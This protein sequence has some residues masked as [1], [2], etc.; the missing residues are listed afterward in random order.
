MNL[1]KLTIL[2]GCMGMLFSNALSYSETPLVL[3]QRSRGVTFQELEKYSFTPYFKG[4]NWILGTLSSNEIDLMRQQGF[5]LDI[6]DNDPWSEPYFLLSTSEGRDPSLVPP[7]LRGLARVKEGIIVKGY[8]EDLFKL[9]DHGLEFVKIH[10]RAIP[11]R[12][13]PFLREPQRSIPAL[14]N[15]EIQ[16]VSDSTITENL[17]KLVNF[18]TRYSCTDSIIAASQWIYEKFIEYGY[19]DVYLDSFSF[20]PFTPLPCSTQWNVVAI[21]QG[22]LAQEEVAIIGAHYDAISMDPNCD[23]DTLAPGADDNASGTAATL[24]VARVLSDIETDITLIFISFGAEE[25]GDFGSEHFAQNAYFSGMNLRVMINMDMIGFSDDYWDVRIWTDSSSIPY[26]SI[27]EEMANSYT[28]LIPL[29]EIG[30][31]PSD[32]FPFYEY[33][34]NTVTAN[35]PDPYPYYHTCNDDLENLNISYLAEVTEM[36]SASVIH[37]SNIPSSPANFTVLNVGDGT[38][39]FLSWDPNIENDVIGYNIYYGTNP[40]EYDSLKTVTSASD[41]LRN[42]SE[43]TTFYLAV[44]A[45]DTDGYESFLTN[46]IVIETT[47]RPLTPTDI[48]ATSL[49]SMISITWKR[50]IGELD[51]AGYN[52]YRLLLEGSSDTVQVGFVPDPT[53]NFQDNTAVP[54]V[55]YGYYVTAVDTQVPPIES[56]PTEEVTGRLATHDRGI[57]IVDNTT[58]GSGGPFAPTD[59]TVDSYYAE[60]FGTYNIGETWDVNDSLQTERA[61]MDYDLG[62]Y[63]GV[64]W[65]SDV[66]SGI[67]MAP[68][69]STMRKYLNG[70]GNFWLSGWKLIASLT[71]MYHDY[72]IFEDNSFISMYMGLDSAITVPNAEKDFIEARSLMGGYPDIKVDSLKVYPLGVLYDMEILLLPFHGTDPLYSYVSKDSVNSQFH[73]LPISLTNRSGYYN[74]VVTDFPLFFMDTETSKLLVQ[75][76]MEM[77]E[78]P[79][80]IT[81][82][83]LERIPLVYSLY[84]NYPNPFN[85]TTTISFDVPEERQHV[86]LTVY[87]LRG[88]HVKTLID[89]ELEP[90]SHKVVWDG[91]NELGNTVS[92]GVYI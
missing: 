10:K 88:R 11:L 1:N 13:G 75:A 39:L 7:G 48:D 3:L 72:Y 56:F 15:L 30:I 40:G 25:P 46:E 9:L 86:K 65:H 26:A 67:P 21:K 36:I 41:T 77:F 31:P 81:E 42:L 27:L 53:T 51:L 89:S 84:Q 45:F 24:E 59:D 76:V 62:I 44:S 83:E 52:V 87:D 16:Q 82:D 64:F 38:S 58:D 91:R 35:H 4:V 66:R 20:E 69:T 54:H 60:L 14:R 2:L 68:D 33:G 28:D 73:G 43:G 32:N 12:K 78:E 47:T 70:G 74:F 23:P 37:I 49:D 90:G 85:P 19:T 63:S 29:V 92:S 34:Y 22:S 57:L 17:T 8:Y 6:L 80:S 55:F 5:I 61:L 79:T 18:K 50:N 71:D